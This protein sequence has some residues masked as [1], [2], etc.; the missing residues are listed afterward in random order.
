M[1]PIYYQNFMKETMRAAQDDM[2]NVLASIRGAVLRKTPATL[3]D[4]PLVIQALKTAD[5]EMCS[6]ARRTLSMLAGTDLG[7]S[8]E[9]WERWW[10][11]EGSRLLEKHRLES[12]IEDMFVTLRAAILEG[13]WTR[14]VECLQESALADRSRDD[15]ANRLEEHKRDVRRAY[16]DASLVHIS[17]AL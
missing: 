4:V 10:A 3:D 2:Q 12:A 15:V 7:G 14:A 5:P 9:A 6:L 8:A 11:A 13:A 16:R 1:S 17:I